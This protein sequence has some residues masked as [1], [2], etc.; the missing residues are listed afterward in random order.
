MV[1]LHVRSNYS[2]LQGGSTVE[3]IVEQAA[4]VGFRA[5][6]LTDVDNLYGA[7]RF[8]NAARSAGLTPLIGAQVGQV[9]MITRSRL[10]Y[11]NLSTILSR[12]HLG[13][14]IAVEECQKD[15]HFIACNPAAAE[16]LRGRVDRLWLEVVRPGTTWEADRTLMREASRLGLRTVA[17]LDARMATPEDHRALHILQ[18]IRAKEAIAWTAPPPRDRFLR[19]VDLEDLDDASEEIAAD[20]AWPFLPAPVVFPASPVAEPAAALRRLCEEGLPRRYPMVSP[21]CRTRLEHELRVIEK[22][23]FVEYFLVVHDIV[24]AARAKGAP[25]AGRGSGA[26][27]LVAYLL[28]ITNVCPLRYR[29]PFERFLHEGRTDYPDLDL[30][31]CWR[32]RDDVIRYVFDRYGWDRVAMVSSHITFQARGAF[33]EV[34]RVHGLS[35]AQI[36]RI[37]RGMG[38]L[39][40]DPRAQPTDQLLGRLPIAPPQFRQIV[41]DARRIHGYP[42]YLSVHPGGVVIGKET[43]DRH[44]PIQ[45]AEKG[46]MISH[47]DKDGIEAV[48]L[49]KI[50]LLGNR[51]VST[52]R[53]ACTILGGFDS[54]SIPDQDP[55]TVKLLK[56]G[57]TIGCNQLE[58]PAMRHLLQM[59]RPTGIA[60]LMKCLA[61]IRPAPASMGMKDAFI[62]RH[63]E[64]EPWAVHPKLAPVLGETYGI[65]L[66][67]DD[68]MQVA[69][70]LAGVPL[71]DGDRL[72]K[73]I[74][75]CRTDED[76]L[77]V[78]KQFLELCAR[79][80][81]PEDVAKDVWVQM[82]K[83]NE[84]SFC[85]SHAASY[86]Q[87]AY[88]AAWL[89]THKP[90]AFW[91]SAL[92]NN[93][94]MYEKRVYIDQAR[95]AGIR[96]LLP[97]INRSGPEFTV[98]G[99][100][101]RMGL[102]SIIGIQH[103]AI[104]EI[105]EKRP[106]KSLFEFA[107]ACPI[108]FPNARSL[109]LAGAFDTLG[110]NRAEHLME[111]VAST[112]AKKPVAIPKLPDTDETVKL[113]QEFAM[114]GL[115]I[116]VPMMTLLWP[117]R[118]EPGLE[119]SRALP[120]FIGRPIRIAGVLDAMRLAD[121]RTHE[122]MEFITLEDEYGVFDVALFPSVFRKFGAVANCYGPFVISGKVENQYGA[123]TVTASRVEL[124][125]PTRT[126]QVAVPSLGSPTTPRGG[127]GFRCGR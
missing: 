47:F 70:A 79:A 15:L 95:R 50:D 64:L 119:D 86:A 52:I 72:R 67:E 30:D 9:V 53:E 113:R 75:K 51:G 13:K 118:S 46:V 32:T 76:R 41:D 34:A 116:R 84:Y 54:E 115:S 96:T 66:Y 28:G 117:D 104:E 45:K 102:G 78:S 106:F 20:C 85:M 109:I 18:A 126:A 123:L 24:R 114:T 81:A 88:A 56:N 93:M 42:H 3:A 97:D 65:M 59:M 29:L 25:V 43:I 124:R 33:R 23:G 82:A 27:S 58:S 103:R 6:A 94:G 120:R 68:A 91:V 112:R 48:G 7:V 122:T 17:T 107:M 57:D 125:Y 77:R 92:N 87:L 110:R 71:A 100:S 4:A 26:S 1:P 22:L 69:A 36:S 8:W 61:L 62:R 14:P 19:Q 99:D 12:R 89:R 31:F 101:I 60:E 11:A 2:L 16:K 49:V 5:L 74:K 83:F 108:T 121:T 44:T 38:A 73:A 127:M 35:D 80:G 21:E 98:E 90:L 39:F 10:G 40:D 111:L 37:Q 63:R 105:L 55:A